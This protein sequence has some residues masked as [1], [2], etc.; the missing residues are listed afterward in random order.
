ME[1][2]SAYFYKRSSLS[3]RLHLQ[4]LTFNVLRYSWH[5]E[6]GPEAAELDVAGDEEGLIELENRLRDGVEILNEEG[7]RRWWGYVEEFAAPVGGELIGLTLREMAN[8]VKVTYTTP[9]GEEAE[10]GWVED[11]RSV[12]TYGTKELIESL[13]NATSS[14]AEQHRD[15]LLAE[16]KNPVPLVAE[17]AR[18][19]VRCRGWGETLT[20]TTWSQ[21]A[22]EKVYDDTHSTV[23]DVGTAASEKAA[24][25]FVAPGTVAVKAH[26]AQVYVK[27]VGNPGDSLRI[28]IYS[29]SGGS[30]GSLLVSGT[31]TAASVPSELDWVSVDLGD[32]VTI[33]NGTTYW[34]VAERTGALDGTNYYQVSVNEDLTDTGGSL[35][36]YAAAAWAARGTDAD[37]PYQF[38]GVRSVSDQIADL[39]GDAEFIEALVA[40]NTSSILT[41]PFHDDY[42][43]RRD[44]LLELLNS[45]TTN[46]RRLLGTVESDRRLI[47]EEEPAAGTADY[48]RG[49]AGA[50]A[51]PQGN[52]V[53]PA[54]CTVAVWSINKAAA[55]LAEQLADATRAF[56]KAATY[57]AQS[58]QVRRTM[59]SRLTAREFFK[60]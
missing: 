13:D 26:S 41:S 6:L 7:T 48:R 15:R 1:L 17:G 60:R 28:A 18:G 51:D 49:P 32:T 40:R 8:R 47:V 20:W 54:A 52:L 42:P 38:Y 34:V 53:D 2:L 14:Y 45:G 23:Q 58:G 11:S 12:A 31:I 16:R 30:P 25:S 4:G 10:T 21:A 55:R 22:G 5:E 9:E 46:D 27:T 57:D 19:Y 36:V 24:Q 50:L 59:R 33:T 39:V 29:N 37:M 43:T 3:E 56:I 35:K 44:V